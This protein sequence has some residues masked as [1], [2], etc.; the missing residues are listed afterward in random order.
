MTPLDLVKLTP[1]MEITSGRPEIGIGLIDGPVAPDHPA[2][3][4]KNIRELLGKSNDICTLTGSAAC[5][6]GTF[7]AGIL[8]G[9]RNSQAPAICPD[10]SIVVRSIF[11]EENSTIAT[12][13]ELAAAI[14]DCVKAGVR[15]INLSLA[16]DLSSSANHRNLV[17]ALSFAAEHNVIVVA[18]AGNQG[19]IGSSAITRHQW[20]IPVVAYD[21]QGKPISL[22]NLAG[23]MGR[24]GLGAVGNKITSLKADGGFQTLSGTSFA[25]PFVTGA[26]ALL[27]SAFPS[28]TAVQVK[29]ALLQASSPRRK[30]ITPP[31]LNAW[32]AYQ[33][34]KAQSLI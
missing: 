21:L 13:E 34:M 4:G 14:I 24:R 30:T 20:V 11:S 5:Q 29:S 10:S 23:S 28:A 6:H 9:S 17:D 25:V 27:W 26:I 19:T 3:A 8:C 7:V 33:F 12:P 2:F 1:V 18:A 32:A 22:S 16:L 31:L 15:I